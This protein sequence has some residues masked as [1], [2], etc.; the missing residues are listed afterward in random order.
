MDF[1][2]HGAQSQIVHRT[3][4]ADME[5]LVG[6]VQQSWHELRVADCRKAI[7]EVNERMEALVIADGD[8][9]DM[10]L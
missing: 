10:R 8:H 6:R 3:P 5:T 7:D 1:Y 4:I 2:I 9:F